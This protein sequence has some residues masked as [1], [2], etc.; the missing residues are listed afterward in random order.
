MKNVKYLIILLSAILIILIIVFIFLLHSL[1]ENSQQ[2]EDGGIIEERHFEESKEVQ[3][4]NTYIYINEI[5]KNF[6]SYVSEEEDYLDNSEALMEVLDKEYINKNNI[7]KDNVLQKLSNYKDITSFSSKEI[8]KKEVGYIHNIEGE[9]IYIKGII[10]KD[11]TEEDI[12][13]LMKQNNYKETYSIS[14]ITEE[15]FKNL[16]NNDENIEID[17]EQGDYNKAYSK[18]I[19]DYQ[20]C[21]EFF[22]DY[23]NTVK[24]NPREAYKLL[25]E[26]YKNK[27]FGNID[28]YVKYINTI[29]NELLRT[30]LKKYQIIEGENEDKYICI[31]QKGNYYIFKNTDFMNYTLILDTYT[32]DLPEFTEKYNTAKDSEKNLLNVQKI[33]EA[34]NVKDY[35]YV[36]NKLEENFKNT[37]F[38]TQLRFEQYI[39][40]KFFNMNE[41]EFLNAQ[42]EANVYIYNVNINNLDDK[43]KTNNLSIMSRLK[44]G[45]DFEI[46]FNLNEDTN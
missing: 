35:D 15:N 18:S 31:D 5:M 24:N 27:R 22:R 43:S 41:I 33:F 19:T 42:D 38:P 23:I 30:V 34:I 29:Q 13:I 7:T 36:Y 16:Q 2:L 46:S 4:I 17:I 3:D 28:N 8:Y 40:S 39:K 11:S 26:E 25:D 45:T 20:K 1:N 14:I 21:L 9:Y 37:Y 32:I 10:R 6:F 12:Y 44:E